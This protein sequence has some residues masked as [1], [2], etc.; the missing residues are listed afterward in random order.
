MVLLLLRRK[1]RRAIFWPVGSDSW[2]VWGYHLHDPP[3]THLHLAHGGLEVIPE[4]RL[5][6]SS[7][8]GSTRP[9]RMILS[10]VCGSS[11]SKSSLSVLRGATLRCLSHCCE[12]KNNNID[13]SL[14]V[15]STAS[16]KVPFIFLSYC[17]FFVSPVEGS[18]SPAFP[19]G[20]ST[21]SLCVQCS[22]MLLHN[23]GE[24]MPLSTNHVLICTRCVLPLTYREAPHMGS[25]T[26]L[27][28]CNRHGTE[29]GL[30]VK[31]AYNVSAHHK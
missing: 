31:E 2:W 22:Q 21:V 27:L 28:P 13:S 19:C 7:C 20:Y 17:F 12:G 11:T 8:G 9:E 24:H 23:K 26:N 1:G 6:T 29:H 15:I 16:S 14:K 4:V 25:Q 18:G 30:R 5:R 10:S 3:M